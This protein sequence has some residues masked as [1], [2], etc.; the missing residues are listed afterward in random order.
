[1]ENNV[2]SIL[3]EMNKLKEK[4]KILESQKTIEIEKPR[5]VFLIRDENGNIVRSS[6]NKFIFE[7]IGGAKRSIQHNKIENY[8][9]VE[10]KLIEVKT[11][12]GE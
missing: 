8:K 5:N 6:N 7:K 9:I 11:H 10:Y 4:I 12:K 1:M 2:D 3:K